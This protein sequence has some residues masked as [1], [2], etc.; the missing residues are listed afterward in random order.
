VC[1]CV[2]VYACTSKKCK[3]DSRQIFELCFVFLL[4]P[5]AEILRSN[6]LLDQGDGTEAMTGR[7]AWGGEGGAIQLSIS[8]RAFGNKRVEHKGVTEDK[9][10]GETD[11][12]R[13]RGG[14]SGRRVSR[15]GGS[16]R[17]A[18]DKESV[19]D[20]ML[21]RRGKEGGGGGFCGKFLQEDADKEEEIGMRRSGKEQK[22]FRFKTCN[23]RV[24]DSSAK[25][26]KVMQKMSMG[27]LA[28]GQ[29]GGRLG[30]GGAKGGSSSLISKEKFELQDF[31][32]L[33][34]GSSATTANINRVI[35]GTGDI[36][37]EG[38]WERRGED[39]EKS[40]E[41]E[42]WGAIDNDDNDLGI[43]EVEKEGEEAKE[44]VEEKNAEMDDEI[45]RV[46]G[47]GFVREFNEG[48]EEKVQ[49]EDKTP[50]ELRIM[51]QF[52]LKDLGGGGA[53]VK[54]SNSHQR[55]IVLKNGEGRVRIGA[56]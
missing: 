19:H 20:K 39:A 3:C 6:L 32:S 47:E 53:E 1:V 18:R 16:Q 26:T 28:A 45:Q 31:D 40:R 55:Q 36:E 50:E 27:A 34:L 48:V 23:S 54:A 10:E 46:D 56:E 38:E 15:P 41:R 24:S 49:Q 9:G 13:E 5:D 43:D 44:A 22:G 33:S 14:G 29:K 42:E 4:Y 2:C 21:E 12:E 52:D 11:I 51:R 35:E 7:G 30:Q 8:G 17:G 25:M 37:R